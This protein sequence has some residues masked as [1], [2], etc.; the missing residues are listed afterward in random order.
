MGKQ[1][2]A[3]A[4]ALLRQP[5][6]LLLDEATSALDAENEGQVQEAIDEL[7]RQRKS[8]ASSKDGACSIIL[9][10]HRLSTVMS[11]DLI[12]VLHEGVVRECGR[13]DELLQTG[14]IYAQLVK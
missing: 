9:I 2:L 8:G 5:S 1:R 13:H 3:I 12:A 10:A 4:R 7:M 14:G 6:L 11:A